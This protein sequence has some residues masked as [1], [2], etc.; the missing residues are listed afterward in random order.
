MEEVSDCQR[1]CQALDWHPLVDRV[2]CPADPPAA[3]SQ[4]ATG[5]EFKVGDIIQ[6]ATYSARGIQGTVLLVMEQKLPSTN[7][8]RFLRAFFDG[9]PVPSQT[10]SLASAL[11]SPS[12]R[13]NRLSPGLLHLCPWPWDVCLCEAYPK[14]QWRPNVCHPIVAGIVL[15]FS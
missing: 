3:Q 8:G 10:V 15:P 7:K 13:D 12:N 11:P 2:S 9:A 1:S 14:D 5:H 4:E 6:T